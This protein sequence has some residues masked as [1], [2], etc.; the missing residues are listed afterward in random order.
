MEQAQK[1]VN[2]SNMQSFFGFSANVIQAN[3]ES[4]D[5]ID[6]DEFI[7]QAAQD[8]GV[9]PTLVRDDDRVKE[10]RD[11]RNKA[12]QAQA[13]AQSMQA[14]INAAEQLSNINTENGSALDSLLEQANA[15]D[16]ARA[17]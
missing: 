2:I 14:G 6:F 12:M 5:K 9:P 4:R 17:V 16:I 13:Q 7:D 3:P 8:M 1:A 15:G 11:Q 10:I